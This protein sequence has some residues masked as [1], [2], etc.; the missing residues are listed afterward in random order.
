MHC[1]EIPPNMTPNT[2]NDTGKSSK[3]VMQMGQCD[4]QRETASTLES[5]NNYSLINLT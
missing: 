4:F 3:I 5:I 1:C 2:L